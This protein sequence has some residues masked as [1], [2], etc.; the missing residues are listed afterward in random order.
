MQAR[1]HIGY[2]CLQR[3][4]LLNK[5]PSTQSRK[6]RESLRDDGYNFVVNVKIKSETDEINDQ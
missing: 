2:S 3:N 5:S 4:F 1:P 6:S